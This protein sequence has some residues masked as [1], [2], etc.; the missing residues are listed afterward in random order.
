[1]TRY[2]QTILA[3][4]EAPWDEREQLLEEV[5][6][7]EVRLM[8]ANGFKHLYI[9]GTAGEGYAVDTARFRRIVDLFFEETRG[10]D[11]H[12]MVGVIGLSTAVILERLAYAY[13]R[14]FRVFQISLPS[15][16][17][18]NDAEVMTFFTD[19]CGTFPD[20]QFLHYNLPRVKRVLEGAD[21]R[22][23]VDAIPNLVATKNT[24]G[25]QPRAAE[26]LRCAPEL[27]HFLGEENFAYGC[28]YGECS[29]LSSLGPM[30]PHKTW[31]YFEA[32]RTRQVE[33]L[34]ALHKG[35]RDLT[36]DV[37][38]PLIALGR[39]DGT[40]DKLIVRLG[41]LEAMPLRMLSPY[42]G[43]TEEQYAAAKQILHTQYP[44]WVAPAARAASLSHI[45]ASANG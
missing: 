41:G 1:M 40:Y 7:Q 3:S 32:G 35:F 17:A 36:M 33:K 9:F 18:L 23:L 8:L 43:L 37:L 4:C 27:Q 34:F 6:R 11:A 28:M 5:F 26:L 29:L 21:Y 12:P 42:Q 14:G 30:T 31:E 2:P 25:G 13:E 24:G 44:E 20:A 22:R 45:Q 19:V 39:I 10:D 16:G 15:W 38:G